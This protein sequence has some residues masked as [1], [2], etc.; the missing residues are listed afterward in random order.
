MHV[1]PIWDV[2]SGLGAIFCVLV[3]MPTHLYFLSIFEWERLNMHVKIVLLKTVAGRL[4][5]NV[6][7]LGKTEHACSVTRVRTRMF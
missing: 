4:N 1:Q 7:S 5:I 3:E 2:S 6:Q